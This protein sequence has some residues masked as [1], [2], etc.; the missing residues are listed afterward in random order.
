MTE[1]EWL[2]SSDMLNL[3]PFL[4]DRGS[5]RKYRL[6]VCACA[7]RVWGDVGGAPHQRAIELAERFAD[8]NA[9]PE[10]MAVARQGL[11]D[12]LLRREHPTWK[13]THD[14]ADQALAEAAFDGFVCCP[15]ID[16]DAPWQ[17]VFPAQA[18]LLRCVF[19]NPFQP[20][21]PDATWRTQTILNLARAA[22]D[23]R[24]LP[25][26]EFE[27]DRIFVLAD[28]LEDAGVDAALMEHL[29]GPWP[30]VR[31]CWAVDLILGLN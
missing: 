30:H 2:A 18:A 9:G 31:G 15:R 21:T 19:G 6:T 16:G 10:E 3:I 13:P 1:A 29:H 28:A 23:E 24:V 27:H 8:G 12:G 20:I 25:S 5:E 14:A 11:L 4:R 7:R 22:Y 26:G 17:E